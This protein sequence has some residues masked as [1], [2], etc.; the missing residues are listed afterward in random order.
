MKG[1]LWIL[2]T[3][4]LNGEHVHKPSNTGVLNPIFRQ[5]QIQKHS[6]GRSR[7]HGLLVGIRVALD[8]GPKQNPLFRSLRVLHI[9]RTAWTGLEPPLQQST[10]GSSHFSCFKWF[11]PLWNLLVHTCTSLWGFHHHV[12]GK[13]SHAMPFQPF[14]PFTPARTSCPL[15]RK[16]P[17][18]RR[19]SASGWGPGVQPKQMFR[20][21]FN[22][23][24]IHIVTPPK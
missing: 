21:N 19:S 9:N 17:R 16:E 18:K 6:L 7:V 3:E 10:L 11:F 1:G 22:M 14:G 24:R 5:T 23:H 4:N 13:T 20:P 15:A 12:G 8:H 2:R